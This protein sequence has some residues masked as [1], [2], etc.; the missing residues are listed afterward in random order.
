MYIVCDAEL[1]GKVEKPKK[2]TTKEAEKRDTPKRLQS[3]RK[4][5]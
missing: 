4:T 1:G 5:V 2:Y 3:V